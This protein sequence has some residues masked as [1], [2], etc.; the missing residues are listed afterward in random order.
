[1]THFDKEKRIGKSY[2]YK[3]GQ[4]STDK[5]KVRFNLWGNNVSIYGNANF[6]IYSAQKCNA[7]CTFCVEELRPA[8]RGVQLSN[9]KEIL[10]SDSKYFEALYESLVA[11]DPVKPT[12]SITGGEP[13]KDPRLPGIL[14][15]ASKFDTPRATI[16]TNASGLLD[17]TGNK[18]VLDTIIE[19]KFGH[20]N[21]SRAHYLDDW[22]NRLMRYSEGP[23]IKNLKYI[24][25]KSKEA[26]VRVRLSCVLINGA[27]DTLGKILKYLEFAELIGVDNVI[28]RQLMMI[29]QKKFARNYVVSFTEAKRTMLDPILYQADKNNEMHFQSQIVGYYYYVEIWRYK[30]IDVI[31]EEADLAQLERTKKTTHNLI[32]ELVFHPNGKLCSTWQPWDGVLGPNPTNR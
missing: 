17:K 11:V 20:I 25:A 29:D 28:F 16:T 31:F 15:I 5:N 6:S 9:Q 18:N 14:S 1:M 22:N 8:S 30:N 21:I 3:F 13:S 23:S 26:G 24:V 7:D 19:A 10:K 27:I 2:S 12:I 4:N 32:H